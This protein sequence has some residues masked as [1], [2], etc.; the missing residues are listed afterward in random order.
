MT[1]QQI[2]PYAMLVAY[3]LAAVILIAGMIWIGFRVGLTHV[4]NC[5]LEAK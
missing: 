3:A 2:G 4:I 5:A 1:K